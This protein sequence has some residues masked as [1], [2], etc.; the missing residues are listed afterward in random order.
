MQIN[1]LPNIS[2]FPVREMV[3]RYILTHRISG[4]KARAQG[5]GVI[6]LV[7]GARGG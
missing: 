4:A 5:G 1:K 3:M 6:L 7:G 2:A